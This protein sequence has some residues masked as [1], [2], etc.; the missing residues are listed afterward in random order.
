M[1]DKSRR[2]ITWTDC[3]FALAA[4]FMLGAAVFYISRYGSQQT[5]SASV[6]DTIYLEDEV[7]V[8]RYEI[9]TF[10]GGQTKRTQFDSPCKL[11]KRYGVLVYATTP[12]SLTG[13]VTPR[14]THYISKGGCPVHAVVEL[15][16]KDL[17][18]VI[19]VF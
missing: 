15:P 18:A 5:I 7:Q 11:F 14:S 1:T 4:I 12:N 17:N 2:K 19:S 6:G 10:A 9:V 13:V 8:P 16:L 3:L